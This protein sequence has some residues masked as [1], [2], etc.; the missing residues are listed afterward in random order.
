MVSTVFALFCVL[1]VVYFLFSSR[2]EVPLMILLHAGIQYG[3]A[4]V[5][6]MFRLGPYLS[7]MLLGFMVLSSFLLIWARSLTYSRE[8][9]GIRIFFSLAQ[10][11]VLLALVIFAT[12]KSPY[13]YLVPSSTWHPDVP[14]HRMTIQ[15]A[16][17][18]GGNILLFTTFF[19][20]ILHWGQKWDL[21]K[22]LVDLGPI[23]LYFGGL[24][25]LRLLHDAQA[26]LP[27]S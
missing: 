17:K 21:R 7:G 19:Q 8:W 15:P 24:L 10:W 3:L 1:L 14:V 12:V 23:L 2:K 16:L 13:Y 25:V 11:T 18:L 26:A 27:F 4:L 9:Q 22:S 5:L 6:W 20:V